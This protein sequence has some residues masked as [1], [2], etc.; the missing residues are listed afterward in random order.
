MNLET[1]GTGLPQ[2]ADSGDSAQQWEAAKTNLSRNS[3]DMSP[4]HKAAI[5]LTAIGP[6][7][8]GDFLKD[9]NETTLTRMAMA[10]SQLDRI[11]EEELDAVIAEFLLSIGTDEEIL[12]GINTARTLLSQVLD[13]NAVEKIMF[14]V[15]G[16]DSRA[17]WKKLNEC[18]PAQLAGFI[19]AEHPQT[20]AV[21][22]S[23]LRPDKA[24][25]V[26]E[27]LDSEFAQLSIFRLS[28]VPA[29][30]TDVAEMVERVITRDFLSA[31]QS[32]KRSRKPSDVIAGLLNNLTSDT[33]EKF[34]SQ[35]EEHNG[36]LA[37][38]VVRTM[39]TFADIRHRVEAR[40]VATLPKEIDEPLLLQA[41]K[42]AQ[43]TK[44]TSAEFIL[45]NISKRL[46]ER[47]GEELE[48]MP[49]VSQ[50]D[51]ES[52]QQDVVRQIQEMAKVGKITLIEEETGD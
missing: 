25:R 46:S 30:D 38:E 6:E 13:D 33:R 35:L 42:F 22:L 5:I 8:A 20:A 36:A 7:M 14:D 34:L 40:D 26:I 41:L 4:L 44:N 3:V 24:A 12:G 29:L 10:I 37:A 21:V 43:Q 50:R 23:E 1:D 47:L 27:R 17:A 51:G 2:V 45:E 9:L 52:A 15:E 11:P 49:E 32:T 19:G 28:R 18:T 31:I 16:G 48:A 39:F